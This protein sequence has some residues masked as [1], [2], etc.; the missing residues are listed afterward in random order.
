MLEVDLAKNPTVKLRLLDE[1]TQK[2]LHVKRYEND[3][4][5]LELDNSERHDALYRFS[6]GVEAE[7]MIY[8]ANRVV[9]LTSIVI[10]TIGTKEVCMELHDE[11]DVIQRRRYVRTNASYAIELKNEKFM[12][13]AQTVNIGG[14]GVCFLGNNSFELG[15][16]F[17]FRL[18][19]PD[20]NT[21]EGEGIIINKAETNGDILIMFNFSELEK[22]A[23]NKI[24]RFCFEKEFNA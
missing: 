5:F 21:F 13:K 6:E 3:R 4:V 11:Y 14:G 19:L 10:D 16:K 15:Q 22:E 8:S 12:F 7:M 20:D 9:K 24:I 1:T 23:R 18:F 17:E 2:V